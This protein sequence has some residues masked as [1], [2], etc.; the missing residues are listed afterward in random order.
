MVAL[1]IISNISIYNNLVWINTNLISVLHKNFAPLQP[2][3][4]SSTFLSIVIVTIQIIFLY[5]VCSSLKIYNYSWPLNNMS[6]NCMG[7][8]ICRFFSI[9]LIQY[10]KYIFSSLW[11]FIKI[12]LF[13]WE[14][15]QA[16]GGA[17]GERKRILKQTPY[18]VQG[19][20]QAWS[21]NLDFMTWAK[22]RSQTFNLLSYLGTPSLWLSQ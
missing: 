15:V 10:C 5:I 13:I 8:L 11:F 4:I 17:E 3:S 20:T 14:R 6:L 16:G 12:Y 2:Q 22:I 1:E 21:Q 18:L 19:P 9:N 7:P